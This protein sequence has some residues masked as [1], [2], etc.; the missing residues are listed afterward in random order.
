MHT[1]TGTHI[2]GFGVDC[3]MH[4]HRWVVIGEYQGSWWHPGGGQGAE[5]SRLGSSRRTQKSTGT[6]ERRHENR[7]PWKVIEILNSTVRLIEITNKRT[8]ATSTYIWTI[9]QVLKYIKS[10]GNFY[11]FKLS[12]RL[13]QLFRVNPHVKLWINWQIQTK[14]SCLHRLWEMPTVAHWLSVGSVPLSGKTLLLV[15]WLL[16]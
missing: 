4:C 7:S 16:I 2:P 15:E 12:W 6:W 9:S 8:W 1:H 5:G 10:F 14:W 13:K 3:G 11:W